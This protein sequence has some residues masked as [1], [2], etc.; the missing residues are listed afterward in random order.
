LGGPSFE[1]KEMAAHVEVSL[2][3]DVLGRTT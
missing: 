3:L 1:N 2:P